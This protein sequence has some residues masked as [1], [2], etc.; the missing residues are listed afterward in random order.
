MEG[1]NGQFEFGM[2]GF[3]QMLTRSIPY[4]NQILIAGGPGTG[5]TLMTFEIIYRNALKGNPGLIILFEERVED[6]IN[7][8]KNAFSE[9]KDIDTL[10]QNKMIKV[11]NIDIFLNFT[12]EDGT[13]MFLTFKNIIMRIEEE[14]KNYK[15]KCVMIDSISMLKFIA[16]TENILIYR[17]SLFY[18]IALMRNYN[19]TAF[20]T[21]DNSSIS[22]E[23]LVFQPEF[24]IFDGIIMLYSGIQSIRREFSLEILK[25][26]GVPHSKA[27]ASYVITDRGVSVLS[28]EVI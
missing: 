28:N 23:T 26:R 2:L 27:I 9:L 17:K 20:F 13:D 11:V 14:I 21:I 18:L 6:F 8:V 4:N 24:Y 10:I 12:K 5:K 25:M 19:I 22:R 7:N 1:N 16:S 15:P 3:D